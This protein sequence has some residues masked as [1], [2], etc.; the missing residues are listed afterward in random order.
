[1]METITL[2]MTP[3]EF[4]AVMNWY[5]VEDK[6]E[7]LQAF[8]NHE[9]KEKN[10]SLKLQSFEQQGDKYFCKVEIKNSTWKTS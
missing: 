7:V 9:V 8:I 3:E 10:L 4:E 1:M 5:Q 2:V 6:K